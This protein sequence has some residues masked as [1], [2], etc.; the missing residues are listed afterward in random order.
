M[1]FI[2]FTF[3]FLLSSCATEH[4]KLLA[5]SI[6]EDTVIHLQQDEKKRIQAFYD[7]I[8]ALEDVIHSLM[9]KIKVIDQVVFERRYINDEGLVNGLLIL[10]TYREDKS[11][12]LL[13]ITDSQGIP[14]SYI[15]FSKKKVHSAIYEI[16]NDTHM[17]KI[18]WFEN[19]KDGPLLHSIDHFILKGNNISVL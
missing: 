8:M 12:L 18:K 17:L 5:I 13:I 9:E 11:Y 14:R 16:N 4:K 15:E 10:G 1:K 7:T 19:S 2:F 6:N 3:I